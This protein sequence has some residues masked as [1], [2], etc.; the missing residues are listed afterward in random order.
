M[1][2]KVSVKRRK[3]KERE[4]NLRMAGLDYDIRRGWRA[5]EAHRGGVVRERQREEW[6]AR[7]ES[8]VEDGD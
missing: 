3:E 2:P 6:G 7:Q 5:S 8:G 4:E 1:P